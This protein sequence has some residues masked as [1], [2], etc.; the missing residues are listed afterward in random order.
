[1]CG[2]FFS[3]KHLYQDNKQQTHLLLIIRYMCIYICRLVSI[4][5]WSSR[6]V[7]IWTQTWV[8]LI[9]ETFPSNGTDLFNVKHLILPYYCCAQQQSFFPLQ[10]ANSGINNMIHWHV[11]KYWIIEWNKQ[12]YLLHLCFKCCFFFFNWWHQMTKMLLQYVQY[13]SVFGSSPLCWKTLQTFEERFLMKIQ[14]VSEDI[15]Q[16]SSSVFTNRAKDETI[17]KESENV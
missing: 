6:L 2:V 4:S 15:V 5:N 12:Y 7:V 11:K 16:S 10:R 9:S 8:F 17:R 1:M 14:A 13:L 3:N